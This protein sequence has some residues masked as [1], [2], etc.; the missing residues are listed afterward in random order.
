MTQRIRLIAG[1]G[2]PGPK[3]TETR[4][5]VGVWYLEALARDR[6][7]VLAEDRKSFGLTGRL[8][9]GD[10]TVRLVVP[11]TYMNRSGQ[12]TSAV[13]D[14]FRIPADAMLVAHDDLDLPPGRIRLKAGGGHGGHNGLR[15]IISRHGNRK[16]FLR[17][18]IGIGHPGSSDQVTP[19]V[20]NRPSRE[21][22]EK[23]EAAIDEAVRHT[24]EILTGN[25]EHAMNTLNGFRA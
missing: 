2:N 6:G 17:L 25:V 23:I 3:Y 9:T 7:V 14:F 10:D 1:L 11:T 20:L 15:D 18:R 21:D 5:N 16:D 22:R 4:H 8:G 13:A 12:A 24:D 19:W